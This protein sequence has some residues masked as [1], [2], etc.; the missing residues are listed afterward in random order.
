MFWFRHRS[1]VTTRGGEWGERGGGRGMR[2]SRTQIDS[3]SRRFDEGLD[4]ARI[5]A[6]LE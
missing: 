2:E 3:D 4:G 1:V 6:H 5:S